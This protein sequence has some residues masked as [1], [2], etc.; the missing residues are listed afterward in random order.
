[1]SLQLF[2]EFGRVTTFTTVNTQDRIQRY[3][4]YDR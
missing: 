1:M 3:P 2:L 4:G